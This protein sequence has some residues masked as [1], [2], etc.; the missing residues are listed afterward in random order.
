MGDLVDMEICKNM[1][2]DEIGASPEELM[3]KLK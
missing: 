3:A 1:T 2:E